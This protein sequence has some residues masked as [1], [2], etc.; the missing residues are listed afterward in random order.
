MTEIKFYL[1]D[2]ETERLTKIKN[3][4]GFDNYTL[5]EYAR[6]SIRADLRKV[7]PEEPGDL[8]KLKDEER[9][10]RES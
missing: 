8:E 1:S 2:E 4:L 5:S 3:W 10:A 9:R 7:F 6:I